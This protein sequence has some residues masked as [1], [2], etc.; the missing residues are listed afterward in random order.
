[1]P[2][3]AKRFANNPIL[4]PADV[5]PSVD[6]LKI[7]CLLNPGAFKYQGRTG[8]L[9][10][11]A[12]RPPQSETSVSTPVID[13]SSLAGVSIVTVSREDPELEITD[14]R[15]FTW[16]GEDYLTTLS[17]LRLA[18]SDDGINF[19]AESVPTLIGEGNL[20]S[21]GIEDCRVAQIG[22]KYILTYS[23]VSGNGVGVGCIETTDWE[24]F[25]RI[26]MIIPP[27]NKDCAIFTEQIDNLYYCLHR[28]SGL[29]IG[30]NFIWLASSPD[31]QN[32]GNHQ[33]IARIRKGMWDSE[34]IGAGAAPIRTEKG[35][36]EIYHGSDGKRYCLGALLL[37]LNDPS[38]V[39]A[40]SEEPIMEPTAD[41]EK[42]G[43]FGH[44]VFTNGHIVDGDTITVYYGAADE[45]I[46]GAKLSI[47]EILKTLG[48]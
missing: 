13:P 32:W 41:Y 6:G 23:A 22:D 20:E 31:M 34:R 12:E 44:V 3:I 27:H 33:C 42:T 24:N 37:D 36:L 11:V 26:G 16:K 9:L 7:E 30:G 48:V 35:W 45:V 46:C 19:F 21:F 17:H 28:P 38:K 40:R 39:I 1:M 8:L 43:F 14:P 29:G 10:R 18:W 4:R 25:K 2:D 5:V 47:Q 15:L